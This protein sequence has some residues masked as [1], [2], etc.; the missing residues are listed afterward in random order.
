MSSLINFHRL[1]GLAGVAKSEK[2]RVR[3]IGHIFEHIKLLVAFV[4]A[5]QWHFELEWQL[6]QTQSYL[7]NCSVWLFFA[8]EMLVLTLQVKQK[9]KY[10]RTNWASIVFIVFGLPVLWHY[11]PIVDALWHIRLLLVLWLVMPWLDVCWR[12]LSDNRLGTTVLTAF[13]GMIMAGM[14]ISGIDPAIKTPLEGIWWAWVTASTVGY[15]DVVPV[16]L[17]GRIF[18]AILILM[19]LALFAALT[20]N[21]SAIFIRRG[22]KEGVEEMKREGEDIRKILKNI[23]AVKKEEDDILHL[24]KGIDKRLKKLES[25]QRE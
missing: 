3:R 15:G 24:L 22:V 6:S 16:S 20:A 1:V 2:T 18:A 11:A 5:V 13:V 17:V 25:N 12:N 8:V 23:K 9:K 21:F 7:L 10:W 4:L 19:G 14:L